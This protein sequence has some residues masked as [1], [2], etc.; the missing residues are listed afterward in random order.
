MVVSHTNFS[1]VLQFFFFYDQMELILVD[2]FLNNF[3]L[4]SQSVSNLTR[5]IFIFCCLL[6]LKER[7]LQHSFGNKPFM[8]VNNFSE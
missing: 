3:N 2:F 1:A 8:I 4:C 6:L 5:K 7:V